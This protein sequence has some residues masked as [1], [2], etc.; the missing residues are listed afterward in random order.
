MCMKL[1]AF[2]PIAILTGAGATTSADTL[3]SVGSGLSGVTA[4]LI[5]AVNG[6][7]SS[8]WEMLLVGFLGL[9]YAARPRRKKSRLE[10][11][12]TNPEARPEGSF[13][14]PALEQKDEALGLVGSHD[15][16]DLDTRQIRFPSSTESPAS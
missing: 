15:D 16:F 13:D 9:G 8:T 10:G 11:L 14:V 12:T 5:S 6:N 2:A 7:E 4:S 3:N 1:L